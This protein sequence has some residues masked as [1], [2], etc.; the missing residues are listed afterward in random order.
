MEILEHAI[1]RPRDIGV[2]IYYV[3]SDARIMAQCKETAKASMMTDDDNVAIIYMCDMQSRENQKW[4]CV[5]YT[6]F[7]M[8]CKFLIFLD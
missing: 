3:A 1:A 4:R 7:P 6:E 2:D 8:F 5:Q